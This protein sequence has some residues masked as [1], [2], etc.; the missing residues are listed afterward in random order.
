MNKFLTNP[1]NRYFLLWGLFNMKGFLYP[2]GSIIN[3]SIML[4]IMVISLQELISFFRYDYASQSPFFK[5]LNAIMVMYTVYGLFLF[6]TDGMTVRSL[7]GDFYPS[8]AFI[9]GAWIILMPIYVVYL[10]TERGYLTQELLQKWMVVFLLIGVSQYYT[11]QSQIFQ[12]LLAQGKDRTEVTN[13]AGYVLLSL[14]PGMLVFKRKYLF[15]IG[16]A[17]CVVFIIMAMKR[18]AIIIAIISLILIIRRDLK[19]AKGVYKFAVL[20]LVSIVVF[21]L[22]GFVD[23]MLE[24]SEY[25]NARIEATFEGDSS[26]RDVIYQKFWNAYLYDSN[27]F[28]WI[29]GRGAMSTLKYGNIYA[30]N[31]WLEILFCQGT[32]GLFIFIRFWRGL[33][34]SSRSTLI[35]E[36]SRFCLFLLFCIFFLKTFFSMSIIGMPIYSTTMMGFALANGFND[37]NTV[38]N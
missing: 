10:Y 12:T 4:L 2:D 15:Y 25:F 3:Q 14:I 11:I 32:V 24:T 31:D 38:I 9:Q 20:F 6:V 23:Y 5:C 22:F 19:N 30:H 21:M 18:G 1:C 16:I 13:G 27:I 36:P 17:V 35:T 26:D 29:F 33:F 37:N 28:Q 7:Y 8:I 34:I